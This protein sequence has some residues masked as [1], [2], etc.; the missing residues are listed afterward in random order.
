MRLRRWI[1]A[2]LDLI[3]VVFLAGTVAVIAFVVL[4]IDDPQSAL[5]PY[6]P[7]TIPALAILPSL[8]PTA[9]PSNTPPASLT[10]TPTPTLTPSITPTPSHTPTLTATNTVS[11]TPVLPGA[12]ALGPRGTDTPAPAATT[13]APLDDGS[14]LVVP[15]TDGEAA[16]V[17]TPLPLPTR[18][19]FPFTT[20]EVTYQANENAEGCA[21]VSVA[22][23]VSGLR[24]EPLVGLAI[25]IRGANF[26]Q[27]QF[28]GAATHLG[29]AGFEFQV[30]T[31]PDA[32]NYTLQLLG[33]GGN[34][35]SDTVTVRTGDTCEA[36]V[37]VIEFVQN[38]AY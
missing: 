30:G 37:A 32:T 4:L 38:H 3:T 13:R 22:G 14:G 19:A 11:P 10:P 33:P 2:F 9:T 21:W 36:N 15:G 12:T 27:V 35:V 28:S 25:E 6:P 20:S 1:T 24:G 5:N 8:T 34:P 16:P 31:G 7:P 17:R 18:S 23:M 29:P 26:N